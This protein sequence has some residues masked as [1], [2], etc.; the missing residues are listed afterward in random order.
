[1]GRVIFAM[2]ALGM[3]SFSMQEREAPRVYTVPGVGWQTCGDWAQSDL[4][5]KLGYVIGHVEANT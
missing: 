2:W 5:F 1:V 3:V 4:D